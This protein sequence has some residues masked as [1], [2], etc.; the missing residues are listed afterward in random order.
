MAELAEWW[1]VGAVFGVKEPSIRSLRNDSYYIRVESAADLVRLYPSSPLLHDVRFRSTVRHPLEGKSVDGLKAA[2]NKAF[3]ERRWAAAKEAYEWALDSLPSSTEPSPS[4]LAPTLYSNLALTLVRLDL[5]ASALRAANAGLALLADSPS[6]PLRLKLLYR[7]SLAL[8]ALERFTEALSRLDALLGA[9]PASA[10]ALALQSR[11]RA[12]LAEHESG[13]SPSTLRSLFLS[14]RQTLAAQKPLS[15]PDI[16]NYLSP[17]L[18]IRPLPGRGNGLIA[19]RPIKRGELLMC[20]K[21]LAWAGRVGAPMREEEGRLRYTAGLS[22]WTEQQDPWGVVECMSEVLWRLGMEGKEGREW[23][24]VGELWAGEELGRKGAEADDLPSRVEGIVT[25]NG[26]HLEDVSSPSPEIAETD[27]FHAPTALYP[28]H[29]SALNHSCVPNVSY[30]FLSTL[31][32]LHARTDIEE[33]EE[34]VDS[35]VDAAEE[36]EGREGKMRGHGFVCGCELCEEERSIGAEGRRRRQELVERAKKI[37]E[38][39]LANPGVQERLAAFVAQLE[40]TY[41]S[42]LPPRL[43]PALYVP[44][45]LLSQ[46]FALSSPSTGSL[47]SIRTELRALAVLGARFEGDEGKEKMV[48]PPL[49]RDMDGVLSALWIAREWKKLGSGDKSRHWVALARDVEAGQAGAEVSD[50]RYGEWAARQ[51]L[52]LSAQES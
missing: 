46:S 49:L 30:T 8:Y 47:D 35:Y 21:P 36:L 22:L 38:E 26:F 2:G 52:D 50:L 20:L 12:R 39:D 14:T 51:G 1:P 15:T 28:R 5:P 27:L 11:C 48:T 16:A 3:K 6:D 25:F 45:R 7:S 31:F 42:S 4:S 32:I 10:D 40:A 43:R 13:P 29:A 19:L 34:L 44:L 33:G 37:S 23:K 18:S 41:S 24:E 17:S 9:D